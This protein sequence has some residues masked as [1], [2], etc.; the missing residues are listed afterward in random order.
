MAQFNL[1]YE[2]ILQKEGG[3][4]RATTDFAS[5]YPAPCT[6]TY[7]GVTANNWHTNKGVTWQTFKTL[8]SSLGYS[9]SCENFAKMPNT[10]WQAIAKKGYWDSYNLDSLKSQAIANLL[11]QSAWG[12]GVYGSRVNVWNKF[13]K[14]NFESNPQVTEYVK[15]LL[16]KG[17]DESK[18]FNAMADYRLN[19]ML[20][21]PNSQPNHEGWKK[22][23]AS[24]KEIS[25][26]YLK[27]GNTISIANIGIGALLVF[28]AWKVGEKLA[29][30]K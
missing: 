12:N 17:A 20:S 10:I 5:K 25:A 6:I 1:I 24:L 11:F 9:A 27:Q 2:W 4:S 16:S 8:A 18:L 15:E 23:T 19:Y 21:I 13:F 29:E 22:R 30:K 28:G 3:L 7:N 26:P 14:K